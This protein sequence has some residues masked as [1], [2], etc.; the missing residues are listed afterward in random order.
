MGLEVLPPD[1]N[2]GRFQFTVNPQGQIIYG[3][4]AIK[5]LGE[6][7][8]EN[9]VRVRAESGTF[10]DLFDFCKRADLSVLNKR[11]LEALIR[12]GAC[13]G[14]GAN[15]AVL[16]AAM[17]EAVKTA[18]Q[19]S[20]VA[21]SGVGDLFGE[22]VPAPESDDV[23]TNLRHIR[24]WSEQRRLQE[25]KETLGL[26]LSGHPIAE[27]LPELARLTRGSISQLKAEKA[28]Q[29]V[30]GL[31]HDIRTI[32]SKRGDTIAILTLDDRSARIEA[33]LFG[34]VYLQSRE[35]LR[36]DTVV[37]VE[38]V[39]STDEY[40]GSGQLQ[41]RTRR[42][43]SLQDARAQHARCLSLSLHRERLSLESLPFLEDLL[44]AHRPRPSQLAMGQT[45][46]GPAPGEAAPGNASTG[47]DFVLHYRLDDVQ[48]SIVFGPEWRVSP[49]DELLQQL[50]ER[51]GRDSVALH[52][53]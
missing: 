12:A 34:E 36:K 44:S 15:R 53:A 35:L 6:G 11:A 13:D 25:E 8:V 3:L 26:Y 7:P 45:G 31:I 22:I 52:Y 5:G 47:C 4:G 43:L 49:D 42:L 18:E 37:L 23:Y 9:L 24:P 41:I 33:S 38:G 50:R 27:Y 21:A 28:P 51:F 19:N 17:P 29:L 46:T 39:V 40:N 30:G 2:V 20:R 1:V 10:R 14:F 16:L 48:G 32:K